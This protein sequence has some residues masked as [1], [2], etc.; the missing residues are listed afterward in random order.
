[1]AAEIHIHRDSHMHGFSEG[2]GRS[3]IKRISK[4]WAETIDVDVFCLIL[5]L[6][7]LGS[8]GIEPVIK[9]DD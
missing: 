4:P 2:A 9:L 6:V 3:H 8:E 5:P 1:M 7:T